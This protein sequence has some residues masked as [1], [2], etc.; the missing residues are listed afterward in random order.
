MAM[1]ALQTFLF[2]LLLGVLLVAYFMWRRARSLWGSVGL[3]QGNIVSMDTTDWGRSDPLYA[4]RFRLAGKPDYLVRVGQRMIPVEVKPNRRASQPYESDVLQL[5]AY[6]LLVEESFGHRPDYGLLRYQERT[7][8][9]PY[10][11]R[12]RSLVL[13]TVAQMRRDLLRRDVHPNHADPSRCDRCGYAED[14]GQRVIE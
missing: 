4:P 6:C 1:S 10:D 14:C 9:L 13:D 3:P 7:F 8:R 5:M 12:L 11:A 2:L